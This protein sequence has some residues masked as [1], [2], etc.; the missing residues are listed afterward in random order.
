VLS[1][2]SRGAMRSSYTHLFFDMD[3]TVT[4]SRSRILP[5]MQE[6][7]HLLPQ[8]VVIV[9]GSSLEQMHRQIGAVPAYRLGQNGNHATREDGSDLWLDTLTPSQRAHIHAHAHEVL[10]RCTHEVPDRD[11][12]IED[13]GSQI[14]LSLYGH[15]ADPAEKKA[16]DPDF[17]IRRQLI[18]DVPFTAPELEVTIGGSTCF[19]Y[20]NK[21][22]NKG[23]NIDR[24]VREMGWNHEECL[25]FGDALFPGGND[26]TVVGVIPTQ[27]VAG[28]A[29][30]YAQLRAFV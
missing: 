24:L 16:F 3:E 1:C 17:S 8:T 20:Y 26:H 27:E 5:E 9:S 18:R 14:S 6:L 12:L 23:Y 13:R 29:D 15:N 21:G 11:D 10:A 2:Y 25:Y 19:D 22:R 30:T 4:P 7:L 28:H